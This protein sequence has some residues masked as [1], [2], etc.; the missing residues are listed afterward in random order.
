MLNLDKTD[1]DHPDGLHIVGHV[2]ANTMATAPWSRVKV[3]KGYFYGVTDSAISNGDLVLD[4]SD[5]YYYLVMSVKAE[6]LGGYV[7]YLDGTLFLCDSQIEISRFEEGE[8][9]NFGRVLTPGL[10]VKVPFAYA[11]TN[12]KNFDVL[13]QKDRLVPQEKLIIYVQPKTGVQVAD[14]IIMLDT[15]DRYRVVSIDKKSI[16]GLWSCQV[17]VDDR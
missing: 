11:T 4:R 16:I 6:R 10:T 2:K 13:E 3:H 1:A 15:M 9:D 8:R 12:L 17:D 14:R 5:N 7:T